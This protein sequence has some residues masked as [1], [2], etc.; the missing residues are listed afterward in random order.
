MLI[1]NIFDP[2]TVRQ[3]AFAA[4][5]T[6]ERIDLRHNRLS[7]IEGGAFLGLHNPKEIY[8]SG[9]QIAHLN[10]DVFQVFEM[11]YCFFLS[12]DSNSIFIY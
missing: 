3:E 5:P 11:N 2:A 8:L 6:I 7:T 10:S 12:F 1:L 9:N 4:Q